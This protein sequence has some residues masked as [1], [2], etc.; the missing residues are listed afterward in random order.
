MLLSLGLAL[1]QEEQLAGYMGNLIP[2]FA[3]VM[4][5]FPHLA[6]LTEGDRCVGVKAEQHCGIV[7]GG[8]EA[9][10]LPMGW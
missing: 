5:S 3:G 6:L 8:E 7:L 4:L 1:G 9:F 2:S 10:L